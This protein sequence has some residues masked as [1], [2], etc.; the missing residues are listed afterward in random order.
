MGSEQHLKQIE[1]AIVWEEVI[2]RMTGGGKAGDYP[3][4]V[5]L[6]FEAIGIWCVFAS[7]SLR[8]VD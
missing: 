2:G 8:R 6:N 4:E 5:K 1:V 7:P 3:P